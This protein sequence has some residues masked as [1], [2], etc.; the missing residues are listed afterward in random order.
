MPKTALSQSE[1]AIKSSKKY[2][3]EFCLGHNSVLKCKPCNS[4][5]SWQKEF[6]V[7]AHRKT[8]KHRTG[9]NGLQKQLKLKSEGAKGAKSI[10]RMVTEAILAADIPLKKLQNPKLKAL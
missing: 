8:S 2:P 10:P 6:N 9:P 3:N 5:V 4:E 1:K 7:E